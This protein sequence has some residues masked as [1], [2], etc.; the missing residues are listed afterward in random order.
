M[1][2]RLEHEVIGAIVGGA[3]A[4][5]NKGEANKAVINVVTGAVVGKYVARLPD[6]LEPAAHPNHRNFFH[7]WLF[8]GT[9]GA[10]MY[11]L[12]KWE[13]EETHEKIFKWGL[14]IAGSAYASH[15]LR[16]SLTPKG[17]PIA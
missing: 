13:P 16:D 9:L 2:N 17:L 1:A 10:G 7:S 12:W 14:L 11:E 8:L 4:N 15:L 6:I 5:L 3:V